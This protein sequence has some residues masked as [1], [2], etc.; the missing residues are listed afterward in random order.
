MDELEALAHLVRAYSPS[1]RERPGVLAFVRLARR[2]GYDTRIDPVG[3]GH[4]ILGRDRP[5][6]VFLGHIDTVEGRLPVRRQGS[7]LTG[8][9]TV[10]A[11]GPLAA[12]LL[13]GRASSGPGRIR[14]IAAVGEET[15]SRGARHLLGRLRPGSV[16]V[17]EPSGWDGITV[18]YKGELRLTATFRGA[19]THYSSPHPT[20]MDRAIDWTADVR[21]YAAAH[22]G[23][24]PF[25]SLTA[26]V[27]ALEG[28]SRGDEET[29]RVTVDLR[30]PPSL[31]PSDT[32][33]GLPRTGRPGRFTVTIRVDPF[34][35]DRTNPVVA[36]LLAGVRAAGGRPTLWRKGGTSDLNL[37]VPAWKVPGAAYGP[38]DAHLDHT[39]K[40]S[41][42][43]A[44]LGRSVTVLTVAFDRLRS[45]PL[46]PRRSD[47]GA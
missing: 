4:A 30:L 41:V 17:G 39:R 43:R 18:G 28:R 42:S 33:R 20:A 13:A 37:V 25:A 40:E 27:V 31:S 11:K 23:G 26:K 34:E 8:R 44:D 22:R 45:L 12:A 7:R 3:N 2:L 35:V 46:T 21:S 24:S 9:G 5:E 15:D 6:V 10:D 36:A 19:R 1:G 14:V 38:G 47:D 16:I 32:L 29:A